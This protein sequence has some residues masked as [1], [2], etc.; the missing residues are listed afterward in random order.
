MNLQL[1]V[2]SESDK[3]EDQPMSLPSPVSNQ[4]SLTSEQ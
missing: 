3:E 2:A 1:E 4:S